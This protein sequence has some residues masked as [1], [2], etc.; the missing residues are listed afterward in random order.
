LAPAN[1]P[2]ICYLVL[3]FTVTAAYERIT[4]HTEC[5][6]SKFPVIH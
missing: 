2:H 1:A 6:L 3:S 4:V 5:Y